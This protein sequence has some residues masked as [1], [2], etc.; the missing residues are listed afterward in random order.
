MTSRG[1]VCV[2]VHICPPYGHLPPAGAR[3]LLDTS[4]EALDEETGKLL[5]RGP[6]RL[7]RQLAELKKNG[8]DGVNSV[9]IDLELPPQT[10][11]RRRPPAPGTAGA[12]PKNRQISPQ[13]RRTM[14]I[15]EY[16]HHQ[17]RRA[18]P[19]VHRAVEVKLHLQR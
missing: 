4:E 17:R 6:N 12:P 3:I 9:V 19:K 14:P 15:K 8:N 7:R 1:H 18:A 5:K 13:R 11:P 2:C 10:K 16:Y